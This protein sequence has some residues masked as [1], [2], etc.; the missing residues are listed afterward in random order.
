MQ[1]LLIYFYT[2]KELRVYS[3]FVYSHFIY[4]LL[5]YYSDNFPI[6]STHTIKKKNVDE[7]G[8][9]LRNGLDEMGI[10]AVDE[11]GIANGTKQDLHIL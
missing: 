7:M 6:S 3:H 8:I 4:F 9:T 11:M 2:G 5:V 1:N 10:K